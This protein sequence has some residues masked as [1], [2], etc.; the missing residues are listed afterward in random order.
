MAILDYKF[1]DGRIE[2]LT[3]QGRAI[4]WLKDNIGPCT[5]D[6]VSGK[7]KYGTQYEELLSE[8]FGLEPT[9]FMVIN[10][11]SRARIVRGDDWAIVRYFIRDEVKAKAK[12]DAHFHVWFANDV[13]ALQ[14]KLAMY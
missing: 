8:I 13:L 4:A 14:F 2:Q 11:K 7:A 10:G 12:K 9:W 3:F 1:E 5:L 6:V